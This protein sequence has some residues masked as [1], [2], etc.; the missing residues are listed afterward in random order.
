M[1]V[2]NITFTGA[3]DTISIASLE[4]ANTYF[5][6]IEW[7]ILF[8]ST[9]GPRFPSPKWVQGLF[10]TNLK[11][12]AHLCS[13]L[14]S[15][16]LK[17]NIAV[18]AGIVGVD[19]FHKFNRIQLNFH[20]LPVEL[21]QSGFENLVDKLPHEII[22]QM[23]GVNNWLS[24]I[25]DT[26]L[27]FDTSSGAGIRPFEWPS[28]IEGRKCGYAGGL[29]PDNLKAELDYLDYFLPEDAVI[30]VDMETKLRTNQDGFSIDKVMRCAEIV[31][32]FISEESYVSTVK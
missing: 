8:P 9:G 31:A 13:S 5:P 17:G 6:F 24:N 1:R 21:E 7:G 2:S 25:Q 3:D 4:E 28:I 20:G 23:D 18:F 30:W 10:D 14:V 12:S 11:L 32:P 15:N 27:L 26:S 29:G 19:L 16:A 22:L